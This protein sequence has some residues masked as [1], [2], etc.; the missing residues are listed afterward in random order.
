MQ[1]LNMGESKWTKH[2]TVKEKTLDGECLRT[3]LSGGV[4]NVESSGWHRLLK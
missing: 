3:T 1:V 4:E 2:G